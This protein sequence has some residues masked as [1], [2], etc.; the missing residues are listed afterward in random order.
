MPLAEPR[1]G[2]SLG[3]HIYPE[4]G[5]EYTVADP[6]KII[7]SSIRH[8]SSRGVVEWAAEHRHGITSKRDRSLLAHNLKLYI[9]QASEFYH[10]AAGGK[11]NTAPLMYYYSFLNLAKALCEFRKPKLH[12][13]SECYAHGLSW[14]PDPHRLVNPER[15]YVTIRGRGIWHVLWECMMREPYSAPDGAK[16]PIRV[17]LSYCPE[18]SSEY[19]T[20]FARPTMLIDLEKPDLLY[21]KTRR[22]AWL[23]FSVARWKLN[24]RKVSVPRLIASISKTGSSYA[25]V[26]SGDKEFRVFESSVPKRLTGRVDPWSG[27]EEDVLRLNLFAHYAD[28]RKLTY[29]IPL[30]ESLPI[31][32]PQVVVYY[33]VLYWLGSLVRYDPHSV[34][35]LIDS[36]YWMIIDGFMSQCRLWLLELF[37]WAL[38]QSE[39]SLYNAR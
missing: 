32:T 7:W 14:R 39:I 27:L 22:E 17:L 35:S 37:R 12:E 13:R 11:P 18:I 23:T 20:I 9:E 1:A 38:Y 31:R 26:K 19:G 29:S 21:R 24:S 36:G 6:E 33:T 15:E 28:G 5:D 8:L 3:L 25:E 10:A 30:Q 34:R 4:F 2:E 16:L